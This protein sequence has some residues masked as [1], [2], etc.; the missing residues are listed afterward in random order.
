MTV[1]L[2]ESNVLF[3]AGTYRIESRPGPSN[4]GRCYGRKL[5][6]SYVVIGPDRRARRIYCSIWGNAGTCYVVSGGVQYLVP[7]LPESASV[8]D[9]VQWGPYGERGTR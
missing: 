4:R 7:E 9:I 2:G 1:N 6:T 5:A 8:W 3:R